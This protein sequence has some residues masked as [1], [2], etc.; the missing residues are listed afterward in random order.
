M[1]NINEMMHVLNKY[2]LEKVDHIYPDGQFFSKESYEINGLIKRIPKDRDAVTADLGTN[3]IEKVIPTDN[4]EQGYIER[5]GQIIEEGILYKEHVFT[6]TIRKKD[7]V[8]IEQM[9]IYSIIGKNIN[10]C[11]VEICL[12]DATYLEEYYQG[13]LQAI[14][15]GL[16]EQY[17][18]RLNIKEESKSLEEVSDIDFKRTTY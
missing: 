15:E 17:I 13:L 12:E 9:D 16:V 10:G 2:G 14:K 3:Y 1:S 6:N 8:S 18:K 7:S 11:N 5:Q 4:V